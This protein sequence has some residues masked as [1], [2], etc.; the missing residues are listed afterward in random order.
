MPE[1]QMA[2]AQSDRVDSHAPSD[3]IVDLASLERASIL[4]PKNG[5]MFDRAEELGAFLGLS[6]EQTQR[7]YEGNT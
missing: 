4:D 2:K 7:L 1:K 6:P 5:L 3:T